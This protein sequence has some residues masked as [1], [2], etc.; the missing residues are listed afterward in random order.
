RM[1]S[2]FAGVPRLYGF[3]DVAPTGKM[4]APTIEA[5]LRGRGDYAKHL[6]RL[7][8]VRDAG[9]PAPANGALGRALQ[10][11]TFTQ[12]SGLALH[13]PEHER[14]TRACFLKSEANS[15][16]ARLEHMERLVAEPDF[17]AYTRAME[18]FFRNHP[19]ASFAPAELA[20][21]QRIKSHQRGHM[22]V[23][24]LVRRLENPTLRL[25]V[26]R[27]SRAVG[28]I[29]EDAALALQRDI[30]LR[31]LA[32]PIYG[33]ARDL[34]CG[35][36]R[37]TVKRIAL[38]PDDVPPS[39]YD[40]EFGIQALGCL[41]PEDPTIQQRLAR[42]LGDDRE[43]IARLAAVTLKGLRPKSPEVQAAL[44]EQLSRP[45][46]GLRRAAA[47][48]LR[49]IKPS[50][51]RVLEAIRRS[52]PTFAIDWQGGGSAAASADGDGTAGRSANAVMQSPRG[53]VQR[54]AAPSF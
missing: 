38:K 41:K 14:E 39:V 26:L 35:M 12:A 32:P 25:E 37:E 23:N 44:A 22:A 43:W 1:Q 10:S 13:G 4:V 18:E 11:S 36:D 28:W 2:V 33:E 21:M 27:V 7:R 50:D 40:D 29:P 19:P 46:E 15:V 51:P 6:K 8:A 42:G 45:E 54:V 47:D 52:D 30:V 20:V 5:Y 3:A 48:A 16:L 53:A 9:Q 17:I 24:E 34:I 49:E 31:L